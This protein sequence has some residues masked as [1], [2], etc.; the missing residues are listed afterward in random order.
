MLSLRKAFSYAVGPI[1]AAVLGMVSVPVMAWL[2]SPGDLGRGAI[3]QLIFNLFLVVFSLGL[4]QAYG[5]SFYELTANDRLCVFRKLLL[6]VVLVS[7]SFLVFGYMCKSIFEVGGVFGETIYSSSM[8]AIYLVSGLLVRFLSVQLR[9]DG[10]G[11]YFS[12]TQIIPK[13]V[14]VLFLLCYVFF[15]SVLD[16]YSLLN[17]YAMSVLASAVFCIVVQRDLILFGGGQCSSLNIAGYFKFGVPLILGGICYWLLS[18]SDRVILERFSN[19]ENLGV[20]S[21]ACNF[22]A[23]GIILQSVFS[24]IWA[25]VVYKMVADGTDLGVLEEIKALILKVVVLVFCV[26]GAL[27]WVIVLVLPESY[28][29]VRIILVACMAAPMFYV[30]SETTVVGIAIAKKTIFSFLATFISALVAVGAAVLLVPTYGAA[31]A[32]SATAIA[33]WFFLVL[34][35]EF[36]NLVWFRVSGVKM[37]VVTFCCLLAVVFNAICGAEFALAFNVAWAVVGGV[38]FVI[39][40]NGF[41]MAFKEVLR[42]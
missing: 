35:T 26:S 38:V 40:F 28:S 17:A 6:V 8:V 18:S 25:P 2:Y 1:G 23:F 39:N 20:Y 15:G 11:L 10:R 14:F 5:R 37:Y 3:L 7:V 9:F 13:F 31:G 34:R 30:L 19:L 12:L 4:D 27:S 24:T 32:A 33:F 29:A 41:K 22:A 36:S 42:G 21:V 16:F